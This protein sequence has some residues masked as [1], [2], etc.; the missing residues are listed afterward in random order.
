MKLLN[1]TQNDKDQKET[2]DSKKNKNELKKLDAAIEYLEKKNDFT[3]LHYDEA[4]TSA[5]KYIKKIVRGLENMT[6]EMIN[7]MNIEVITSDIIIQN[8]IALR[9]KIINYSS[10]N[11]EE[12]DET[13]K[14]FIIVDMTF[15]ILF[16]VTGV[17]ALFRMKFHEKNGTQGV[18]SY[19]R[20]DKFV[21]ECIMF[22]HKNCDGMT[23]L[24][25]ITASCYNL[26]KLVEKTKQ[27]NILIFLF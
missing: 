22:K 18:L 24:S 15:S 8:S 14:L 20:D 23:L 2:K 10:Q 19:L 1:I 6:T 9:S 13:L 25:E 7:K 12:K 21:E 3:K 5:L 16:S 17:S 27:V 4:G 11:I 26:T